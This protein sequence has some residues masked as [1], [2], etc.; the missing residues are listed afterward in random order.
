MT[1]RILSSNTSNPAYIIVVDH[2]GNGDYTSVQDAMDYAN[3]MNPSA[4]A[5]WLVLVAPGIYLDVLT[6]YDYVNIAGLSPDHSTILIPSGD[7]LASNLANCT[8]SNL[9]IICNTSPII[10]SGV[11]SSGKTLTMRNVYCEEND[12]EIDFLELL[13]GTVVLDRCNLRFGGSILLNAGALYVRESILDHYHTNGGAPTENTIEVAAS[14]TLEIVRSTVKNTSPDGSAI[15]FSGA[16][17]S[18]KLLHSIFKKSSAA[19]YSL[20]TAT[21]ISITMTR[22]LINASINSNISISGSNDTDTTI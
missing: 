15:K 6:L 14:T 17:T 5:Q 21:A 11:G 16:P 1:D 3:S 20:D 12:A 18:C 7:V 4:L 9:K 2:G 22:C 19:T 13:S 10:G 8:I